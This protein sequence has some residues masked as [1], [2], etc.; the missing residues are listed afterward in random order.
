MGKK[1]MKKMLVLIAVLCMTAG[2]S[3]SVS[4]T[5]DTSSQDSGEDTAINAT[6]ED[7]AD[8]VLQVWL[9]YG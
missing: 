4:A 8:G 6:T 1:F 9:T 7:P 2:M 5:E 3:L